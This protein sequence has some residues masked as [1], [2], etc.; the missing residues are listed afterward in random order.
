MYKYHA[1]EA[2]YR[3]YTDESYKLRAAFIFVIQ[4]IE[5][6]IKLVGVDYVGIGSDFDGIYQP[7]KQL[8]DVT[9]Y[10]LI[11]KALV[12]KGYSEKDIDKILGGNLLRV[13]KA[14]ETN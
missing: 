6:V 1:E 7:P 12:E 14:N 3:K 9:T 13:F 5:Y 4:H 8:D 10:P 11:T 2:M